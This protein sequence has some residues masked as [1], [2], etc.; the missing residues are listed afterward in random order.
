MLGEVIVWICLATLVF[1]CFERFA[2]YLNQ[3]KT[4]YDGFDKDRKLKIHVEKLAP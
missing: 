4:I 3:T 1:T 2:R